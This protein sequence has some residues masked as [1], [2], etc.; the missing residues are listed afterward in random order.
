MTALLT[1]L[2]AVPALL[3]LTLAAFYALEI[4]GAFLPLRTAPAGAAGP[5]TV[6]IPAHNESDGIEPT[7]DDAKHQL[8]ASDRLLVVADNC[9]DDTAEVAM[10]AGAAVLIRNDPARRGKGYALQFAL[11]ALKEKPPAL[12]IFIDADCRLEEGALARLAGA[13]MASGRP[14]QGLYLLRAGED[15]PA[16][17]KAAEFAWLLMNRVRMSGLF[18][19]FDVCR[20]TGSGM[21]IP[22]A[23]A[24]TLDLASGEI[25]EDLALGLSLTEAG[26]P[27]LF[28]AEARI[29]SEFPPTEESAVTQHARWEHGSLRLAARAA[30]G[31]LMRAAARGDIRLAAAA[32]DLAIPPL[33][34]FGALTGVMLLVSALASVAGASAPLTLSAWAFFLLLGATAAAWVRFGRAALPA[35]DFG[36]FADYLLQKVKIYGARARASTKAWTRT[37]REEEG[38]P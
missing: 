19:L 14:S 10:R 13:A 35:S 36:A 3:L 8:R 17:R 31:L 38:G 27:P 30:P 18:T 6:I 25:V 29:H 7:L 33:S 26:A 32:L 22:W 9:D 1:A 16:S 5:L 23:I 2:L 4:I 34:V 21:A 11:D 20:L 12:V 24:E 15:A 28:C 37:G